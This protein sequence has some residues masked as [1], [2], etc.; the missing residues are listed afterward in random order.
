VGANCPGRSACSL[1]VLGRHALTAGNATLKASAAADI[2]TLYNHTS[3]MS[4][5]G[6]T[7]TGY[8]DDEEWWAMGWLRCDFTAAF[9]HFLPCISRR[10]PSI[11]GLMFAQFCSGRGS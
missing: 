10:F 4:K 3:N 1:E 7:L 6:P 5:G 8:Y 2:A 11:S 9:R